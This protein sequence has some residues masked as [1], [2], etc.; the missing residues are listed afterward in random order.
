[1]NVYEQFI[2]EKCGCYRTVT[3]VFDEEF[4]GTTY[5]NGVYKH[6]EDVE[7]VVGL[8]DIIYHFKSSPFTEELSLEADSPI[9]KY[10]VFDKETLTEL[11]SFTW[12]LLHGNFFADQ[13]ECRQKVICEL[14]G[15]VE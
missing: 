3:T 7:I 1:M 8:A 4:P 9:L 6:E 15:F 10:R 5:S 12:N 11:G 13:S 14:L 2:R